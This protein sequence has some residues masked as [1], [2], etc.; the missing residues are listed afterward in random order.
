MASADD[1]PDSDAIPFG[2]AWRRWA[3]R[4]AYP[5]LVNDLEVGTR[6]KV[7]G[8]AMAIGGTLRAPVSG[9]ECV[10][11]VLDIAGVPYRQRD[12]RM[13]E[14]SFFV[15]DATG[16]RLLVETAHCVIDVS[17]VRLVHEGRQVAE[18]IIAP[19][20]LAYAWGI[21]TGTADV[22]MV[23]GYRIAT[24]VG[25]RIRSTTVDRAVIGVP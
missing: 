4:R 3:A 15:S 11:W 20:D 24:S 17:R 1:P 23:E 14:A 25:L 16:E 9:R 19:G 12:R 13:S 22:T 2:S 8:A 18:G 5:S 10:A 6:A 21:V 7:E